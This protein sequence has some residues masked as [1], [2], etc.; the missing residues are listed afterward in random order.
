MIH[1]A[2]KEKVGAGVS[3]VL[4]APVPE[5]T[6][7][8][9]AEIVPLIDDLHKTEFLWTGLSWSSAIEIIGAIYL[10]ILIVDKLKGWWDGRS[11]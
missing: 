8:K 6:S 5:G 2:A 9:A 4:I 1:L 7:Q 11:K 10:I 3:G